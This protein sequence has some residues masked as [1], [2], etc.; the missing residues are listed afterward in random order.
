MKYTENYRL[1]QWEE[2]DRILRTDFNRMCADID[3]GF[4]GCRREIQEEE[5]LVLER[6][7]RLAYNHYG[8]FRDTSQLPRQIGVVHQRFGKGAGSVEGMVR[9]ENCC[10]MGGGSEPVSVEAFSQSIDRKSKLEVVKNT[11]AVSLVAEFT[12][13]GPGRFVYLPVYGTYSACDTA[14]GPCQVTLY[15]LD[16]K[17]TEKSML[18]PLGLRQI[19]GIT[20]T[21]LAPQVDLPFHGGYRYRLTIA[22]QT[23]DY[24]AKL[25]FSTVT[26]Y[27]LELYSNRNVSVAQTLQ[28]G[29]T[30]RGGLVVV[31]YKPYGQCGLRLLWDGVAIP[32]WKNL[33]AEGEIEE[34]IFRRVGLVSAESSLTLEL[35]CGVNSELAL[36]SLGAVLL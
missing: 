32:V 3:G 14:G 22:P 33:E 13:P 23:R 5:T 17:R 29:E 8:L 11:S 35:T 20:T 10:Y 16:E 27:H 1:P 18:V 19:T 9:Q 6:L 30:S 26:D 21:G 36:Y 2:G 31:R 25:D 24:N 28:T 4:L 15:N 7:C 34:M 12:A